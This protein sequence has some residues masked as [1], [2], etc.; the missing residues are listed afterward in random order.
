MSG[1]VADYAS[2]KDDL[3]KIDF[4][5]VLQLGVFAR[6]IKTIKKNKKIVDLG[7]AHLTAS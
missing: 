5:S 4:C 3:R 2:G 1:K 6:S 7:M